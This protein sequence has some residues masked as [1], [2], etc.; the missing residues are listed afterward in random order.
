[1]NGAAPAEIHLVFGRIYVFSG[2][3]LSRMK[4]TTIY[5]LHIL[6]LT[7][8]LWLLSLF[9]ASL[10]GQPVL[11]DQASA[12]I[13][14]RARYLMPDSLQ[15]LMRQREQDVAE[16]M[17]RIP[18]SVWDANAD[19]S[20]DEAQLIS[21]LEGLVKMLHGRAN[22]SQLVRDFGEVA[23][24]TLRISLPEGKKYTSEDLAFF[25]NYMGRQGTTFELVIY[26]T[27]AQEGGGQVLREM[28]NEIR[29]RRDLC[30]TRLQSAY[31]GPFSHYPAEELNERS[32]FYGVAQL[33]YSHAVIDI[34]RFWLWIWMEANGDLEGSLLLESYRSPGD[35]QPVLP[36]N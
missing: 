16:G 18:L 23:Q 32:P 22:F 13:V 20:R 17:S 12:Q 7:R 29:H 36:R 26:D 10:Q 8:L 31:L 25:L 1:L 35:E 4:P 6:R 21:K 14:Y 3:Y 2:N 11:P 19:R 15:R 24:L 9:T 28:L 34:A 33:V 30:S 5:P 27:P